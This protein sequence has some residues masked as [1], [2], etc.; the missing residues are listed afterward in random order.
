MVSQVESGPSQIFYC[1]PR[2]IGGL[3]GMQGRSYPLEASNLVFRKARWKSTCLSASPSCCGHQLVTCSAETLLFSSVEAHNFF[4]SLHFSVVHYSPNKV[5]ARWLRAAS[6][7][8]KM[9]LW[10]VSYQV[11]SLDDPLEM[12]VAFS[13]ACWSWGCSV[14]KVEWQLSP[15]AT[16]LHCSCMDDLKLGGGLP[17]EHLQLL[18]LHK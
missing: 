3:W 18:R 13:L 11:L 2:R 8:T 6:V 17:H 9:V 5:S 4:S 10:A 12:R 16:S 7:L 14:I 15:L 1:L